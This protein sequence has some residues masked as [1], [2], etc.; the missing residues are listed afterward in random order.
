MGIKNKLLLL[1]MF[2]LALISGN[3]VNV[4]GDSGGV[5]VTIPVPI[6][7][8]VNLSNS[9]DMAIYK[10][11]I[12]NEINDNV[13]FQF[14]PLSLDWSYMFGENNKDL[15]GIIY[16]KSS[17]EVY[18]YLR[19]FNFTT[20]IA[21]ATIIF[22]YASNFSV[23]TSYTFS[24]YPNIYYEIPYNVSTMGNVTPRYITIYY[25][26]PQEAYN[27][28][29][30]NITVFFNNAFNETK[31]VFINL[32]TSWNYSA[33]YN[34]E[35]PP[36]ESYKTIQ[37]QI[38]INVQGGLQY[39]LFNSTYNLAFFAIKINIKNIE[40]SNNITKVNKTEILNPE[41][42]IEGDKII[43]YNPNPYPIYGFTYKINVS[44]WMYNFLIYKPSPNV[45]YVEGDNYVLVY[46]INLEPKGTFIIRSEINYPFIILVVLIGGGIILLV[47]YLLFVPRVKIEKISRRVNSQNK[48]I[49]V[50]L[51]IKN[52]SIF[53]LYSLTVEDIIPNDYK[54]L[55]YETVEPEKVIKEENTR[56]IW[57]I[58]KIERGE[59][60]IISYTIQYPDDIKIIDLYKASI[61]FDYMWRRFIKRSN[62]LRI[63]ILK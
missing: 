41:V 18:I 63:S 43:I 27:G 39:L 35:V 57:R 20:T 34:F 8:Y 25:Y 45:T 12:I 44:K 4:K 16:P 62:G 49:T 50:S 29:L 56:I 1:L 28:D 36:G 59:E 3:P 17:K 38:P 47:F 19:P 23:I 31:N 21:S 14:I 7:D 10:I 37:V 54:I 24:L 2:G 6:K 58:N 40:I 33:Q 32:V 46:Y 52:N 9:S 42:K 53:P 48:T 60:I 22:R 51:H 13:A 30:L 26:L 55:K 61:S 15:Y 5:Y 11:S